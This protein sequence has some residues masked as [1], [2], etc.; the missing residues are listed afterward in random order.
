MS[1]ASIVRFGPFEL[2]VR[3]AELRKHGIPLRLPEQSFQILLMLMEKPGEVV[4]RGDIRLRLWPN[5]TV[6]DFDQSISAAIRRLRNALGESAG[7]P[8]YIETVSKRGYRFRGELESAA[9][10]T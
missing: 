6:V 10:T 2:D 7:E 4:S 5:D 1:P 3:S 8:G 9:P